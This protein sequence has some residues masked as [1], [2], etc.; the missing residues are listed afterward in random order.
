MA[1]LN[2]QMVNKV[3]LLYRIGLDWI[4]LDMLDLIG[5]SIDSNRLHPIDFPKLA[6]LD[7]MEK[8]F[9]PTSL[10]KL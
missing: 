7:W 1:M 3:N 4:G 5:E 10:G 8:V 9:S 2:N 6:G